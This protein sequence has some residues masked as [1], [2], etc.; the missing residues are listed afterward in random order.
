MISSAYGGFCQAS[1]SVLLDRL[2]SEIKRYHRQADGLTVKQLSGYKVPRCFLIM[3]GCGELHPDLP[4]GNCKSG[5]V[6]R[7]DICCSE[8]YLSFSYLFFIVDVHL[9]LTHPLPPYLYF[10]VIL[11]RNSLFYV[12]HDDYD[13]KPGVFVRHVTNKNSRSPFGAR[14]LFV[15][16]TVLLR[17]VHCCDCIP[18]LNSWDFAVLC[19]SAQHMCNCGHTTKVHDLVSLWGF[20]P[21]VK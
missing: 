18:L 8:I 5:S 14:V 15:A 16:S 20:L 11:Q 13:L 21:S 12:T 7:R 19:T 4:I 3:C 17:A 10:I 9:R 6:L 1:N 2:W